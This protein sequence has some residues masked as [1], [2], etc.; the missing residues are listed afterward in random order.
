[1]QTIYIAEMRDSMTKAQA[2]KRLV[3]LGCTNVVPDGKFCVY[4]TT[5]SGNRALVDPRDFLKEL[6]TVIDVRVKP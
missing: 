2:I 6:G 3:A 4:L 5:P 1:M